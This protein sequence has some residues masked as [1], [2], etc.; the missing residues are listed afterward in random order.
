MK[1]FGRISLLL[2][3]VLSLMGPRVSV[4]Q[5]NQ[6]PVGGSIKTMD[7]YVSTYGFDQPTGILTA[8]AI[9]NNRAAFEQL[10]DFSVKY[11]PQVGADPAIV[12]W[13][14]LIKTKTPYNPYTYNNCQGNDTRAPDFVCQ[15]TSEG[16]ADQW[17]VGYGQPFAT[18][19][20]HLVKA[21]TAVYGDPNDKNQVRKV[22]QNVI[23]KA[24][25]SLTATG[26]Y[27][28]ADLQNSAQVGQNGRLWAMLLS[29]DPGISVYLLASSLSNFNRDQVFAPKVFSA[30]DWQTYS[31][32]LNDVLTAW[33][34]PTPPT[35]TTAAPSPTTTTSTYGATEPPLKLEVSDCPGITRTIDASHLPPSIYPKPTCGGGSS[36]GNVPVTNT[37]LGTPS[38]KYGIGEGAPAVGTLFWV[39]TGG[40]TYD[41]SQGYGM[42]S[43]VLAH[44]QYIQTGGQY[45]YCN[46]YMVPGHCGVDV[47]TPMSTLVYTPVAGKVVCAGTGAALDPNT[48][49]CSAFDSTVGSVGERGRFEIALSNGDVLIFGHMSKITVKAGQ[50]LQAGDPVGLTGDAGT[51]PHFHLE[52]RHPQGTGWI[53]YDPRDMLDVPANGSAA[54]PTPAASPVPSNTTQ[55][56]AAVSLAT[57]MEQM[58]QKY[59]FNAPTGQSGLDLAKN[60][61]DFATERDLAIKYAPNFDLEPQMVVWWTFAETKNPYD[62]YHYNNCR[63]N[64]SFPLTDSCDSIASGNWQIGYGQQYSASLGSGLSEAFQKTHGDV[65]DAALVAQVGQNVLSKSGVT[66][67]FP[68]KSISQLMSDEVG[69][70]YWIFTLSRDPAMSVYLLASEIRGDLSGHPGELYRDVVF[71]WDPV[72]YPALWPGYSNDMNDILTNWGLAPSSTPGLGCT[73]STNTVATSCSTIKDNLQGMTDAEFISKINANMASYKKISACANV[74]WQMMAAIHLRETGLDPNYRGGGSGD[75]GA[76]GPW[77]IDPSGSSWGSVDPYNFEAAGCAVAKIELQAKASSGPVGRPLTATM[78][79]DVHDNEISIKDAF[80]A[81]N[82]RGGYQINVGKGCTENYEGHSDWNFDCSAYVMTNW[83]ANHLGMCINDASYCQDQDGTWKVYYKLVHSTYGSDGTLLVYGGQCTLTT[84]VVNGLALPTVANLGIGST[85]FVDQGGGFYHIGIDISNPEG[86]PVMAMANGDILNS[87]W[88]ALGGYYVLEHVPA[89]VAGN[90]NDRWVYYGHLDPAG[91]PAPGSQVKAGQQIG[92]TG[93]HTVVRDGQVVENGNQSAPHLHFDIRTT[94]SG[95]QDASIHVNPC[96][97]DLFKQAYP[98]MKCDTNGNQGASWK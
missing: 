83:D 42:T 66:K 91:L 30:A 54:T 22:M 24:G 25:L 5:V 58:Q 68:Q 95:A 71:G 61:A 82:G 37:G 8:K 36:T 3:L 85:F 86:S 88:D 64:S 13:W 53:T 17:T 98:A 45:E 84:G 92:K 32:G 21:F 28:V 90:L 63:N 43:Y 75:G 35:D 93:P 81:Y 18:V 60:S 74:P 51:G 48:E 59:G 12:V 4:G 87:G 94:T 65:N 73:A 9:A 6:P 7:G 55:V 31:N 57:T 41:I 11:A 56:K 14:S 15:T 27:S 70:R 23:N 44:P 50:Q 46:A 78:D 89:N 20:D 47:S 97:I 34:S 49:A 77:Q 72:N 16:G 96:S 69:N 1:H 79:P 76:L 10:R 29:R 39:I 80:F 19:Y 26:N 52:Y 40:K 38:G 67:A 33:G 2:L 62:S